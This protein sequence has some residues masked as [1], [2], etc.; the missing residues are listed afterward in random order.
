MHFFPALLTGFVALALLCGC[1]DPQSRP[2]VVS[3]PSSDVLQVVTN[4]LHFSYTI[5][6]NA[7]ETA[8]SPT[9]TIR[10]DERF[11]SGA[12]RLYSKAA[13]YTVGTSRV[14]FRRWWKNGQLCEEVPMLQ[15]VPHGVTRC[16]REDGELMSES[17]YDHG[18]L[19]GVSRGWGVRGSLWVETPYFEGQRHGLHQ[20]WADDGR[21]EEQIWYFHGRKHGP[22]I[23][24]GGRPQVP[25]LHSGKPGRW[26]FIDGQE[27]SE[28][29]YNAACRTNE[30]LPKVMNKENS[31][32]PD[33]AANGSQPIRSETNSTSPAAGSRR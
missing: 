23:F 25:I 32:E 28:S 24:F 4:G 18:R 19:H 5:P 27:V 13:L 33:G 10:N 20:E 26:Y 8:V 30:T 11:A 2:L 15:G 31:V 14:G 12:A 22:S 21:L 29:A 9:Y 6:S 7:V 3:P 17:V 16:W 1:S